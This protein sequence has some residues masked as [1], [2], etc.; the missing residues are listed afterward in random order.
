[1]DQK[2]LDSCVAAC[3]ACNHCAAACLQ[4]PDV[5]MMVR[6]VALDVDC[7]ALCQLAAAA[8]ARQ[9]DFAHQ[10]CHLCASVC[11]PCGDECARHDMDHCQQC[12]AACLEC[13]KACRAM[14][15]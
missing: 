4:E 5:K 13:A 7:A 15:A 3:N 8:M 2:T 9:S 1:M 11:D 12:A 14:T 10:I 6:C